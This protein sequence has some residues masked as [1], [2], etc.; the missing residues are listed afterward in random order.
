MK[1]LIKW[2]WKDGKLNGNGDVYL[3]TEEESDLTN[4]NI[5]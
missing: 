4:K 2:Y 3:V 5:L 1:E